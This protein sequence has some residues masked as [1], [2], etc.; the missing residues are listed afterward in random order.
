MVYS[1]GTLTPKDKRTVNLRLDRMFK[2][3]NYT[4]GFMV[5]DVADLINSVLGRRN[6]VQT[7]HRQKIT[8]GGFPGDD[9]VY[10]SDTGPLTEKTG[11]LRVVILVPLKPRPPRWPR[12]KSERVPTDREYPMKTCSLCGESIPVQYFLRGRGRKDNDDCNFCYKEARA[13]QRLV[14]KLKAEEIR[15]RRVHNSGTVRPLSNFFIN[16]V[17]SPNERNVLGRLGMLTHE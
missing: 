9:N 10:S 3:E 5:D 15:E 6:F 4:V 12:P 8:V 14:A 16:R 7:I 2:R 17:V 11:V 13:H 1:D